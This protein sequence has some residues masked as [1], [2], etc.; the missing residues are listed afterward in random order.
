[1]MLA[2]VD[3]LFSAWPVVACPPAGDGH[4]GPQ[5]IEFAVLHKRRDENHSL[6]DRANLLANSTKRKRDLPLPLH[7]PLHSHEEEQHDDEPSMFVRQVG[8][9]LLVRQFRHSFTHA[10]NDRCLHLAEPATLVQVL[11]HFPSLS[12]CLMQ[13]FCSCTACL[14]ICRFIITTC[15]WQSQ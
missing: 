6:Y 11:F 7:I 15:L 9:F 2:F 12:Q 3:C 14:P 8:D 10:G 5:A 1:M 13:P 4:A